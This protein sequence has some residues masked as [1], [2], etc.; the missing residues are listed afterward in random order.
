MEMHTD[1]YIHLKEKNVM[2]GTLVVVTA[3]LNEWRTAGAAG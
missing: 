2:T 3:E 1:I